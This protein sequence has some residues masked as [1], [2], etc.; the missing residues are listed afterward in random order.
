MS[1][2]INTTDIYKFDEHHQRL[3]NMDFDGVPDR[4]KGVKNVVAMQD[5][6]SLTGKTA[7][8]TGGARGLGLN[9]V[10][11]LAEAGACVVIVDIAVDFA[12]S[13]IEFFNSKNYSVKFIKTD[14]R[15]MDQIQAA[16]DFAVKEF[17]GLDILV[18]L[19]TV[20]NY[21][22]F[23]DFT[24]AEYDLCLD[25]IL[26]ATFFFTQIAGKQMEKQGTGG[27][28]V[29]VS[30]V[31]AYSMESYE[32][33][34][35]PY[36]AAKGGM[37]ALS[38]SLTRELKPKGITINTVAPGGMVTSSGAHMSISGRMAP[39]IRALKDSF[40]KVPVADPDE[41][42]RVIYMMTT[43][44]ASYMHGADVVVDGGTRWCLTE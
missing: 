15:D 4:S 27:K 42:A 19:A 20:Y 32:G 1:K 44:V 26:K 17:G 22:H 10:N 24:E 3:F 37:L 23:F 41:V 8:V 2:N 29:N 14:I 9:V 34:T 11:R 33:R 16:V 40:P 38:R 39:D 30:S 6:L 36:V 7:I 31:A 12:E 43:D 35:T 21:K 13:A 25:V 28:I 5:L 18:N